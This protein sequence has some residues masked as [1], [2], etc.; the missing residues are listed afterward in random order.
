M[1]GSP[2]VHRHGQKLVTRKYRGL[3]SHPTRVG[4]NLHG[5]ALIWQFPSLRLRALKRRSQANDVFWLIFAKIFLV[6]G[7]KER[8]VMAKNHRSDAG[9]PVR[10]GLGVRAVERHGNGIKRDGNPRNI[11]VWQ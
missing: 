10:D 4:D 11:S 3:D 1:H 2:I 7:K 6:D 5:T 9:N 8:S